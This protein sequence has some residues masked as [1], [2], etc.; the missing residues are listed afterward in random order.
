[1]RADGDTL[2]MAETVEEQIAM[3][4]GRMAAL[5][6]LIEEERAAGLSTEEAERVLA[7]EAALLKNLQDKCG[8]D[9]QGA[10]G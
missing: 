4:R 2:V 5:A 8:T 9:G 6:T 7:L 10:P 1:V 3:C